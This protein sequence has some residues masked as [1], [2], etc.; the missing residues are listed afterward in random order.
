MRQKLPYA[1]VTGVDTED[2]IV[3]ALSNVPPPIALNGP[4]FQE[5]GISTNSPL[6]CFI[7]GAGIQLHTNK[8]VQYI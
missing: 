6:G 4:E 1:K 3:S 8:H 2:D 5:L 7:R